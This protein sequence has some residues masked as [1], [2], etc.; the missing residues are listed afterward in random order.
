MRTQ[1]DGIMLVVNKVLF[2]ELIKRTVFIFAVILL[3]AG[4]GCTNA[5]DKDNEIDAFL[6]ECEEMVLMMEKNARERTASLVDLE[7]IQKIQKMQ[8]QN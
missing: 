5:K 6:D 4:L 8:A 1:G 3:L 2:S 7:K